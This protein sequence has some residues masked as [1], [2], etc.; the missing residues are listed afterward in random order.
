MSSM[1]LLR[2][3]ID[4]RVSA[5]KE[6]AGEENVGKVIA[7]LSKGYKFNDKIVRYSQVKVGC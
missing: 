7:V 4:R 2:F 1:I 3:P 6:E 5:L